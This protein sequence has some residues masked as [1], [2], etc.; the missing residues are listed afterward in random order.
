MENYIVPQRCEF[1]NGEIIDDYHIEK[2]LGEG[3]F[4]KV[5][6]V[7]KGNSDNIYALK[8]LKLWQVVHD[9][10]RVSLHKRFK[11][12]FDT[13]QINSEYLVKSMAYGI[14]NGNPYIV[15]KYC[16]NGDLRKYLG[17]NLPEETVDRIAQDILYGLRDLHA[18]GKVH[19]DIKPE[20]V[21]FDEK[22]RAML[23]DFGI[24]GDK[25]IRLTKRDIFGKNAGIFGTYAYMPP[26][27]LD[28]LRDAT[29]LPTTDFFSF[30]VMMY[31]VFTNELP[32]GELSSDSDLTNYIKNIKQGNWDRS[33]LTNRRISNKWVH[34][35]E[36]CVSPSLKKRFQNTNEIVSCIGRVKPVEEKPVSFNF[37]QD[38]LL[39]RIMQG[40][41]Y[42]KCYRLSDLVSK[43][44]SSIL[45][46]GRIDTG[47]RNDIAIRETESCYIS[48]L[49]ATIEKNDDIQKWVI[50]DGQ[51]KAPDMSMQG[52]WR[53]STNGTYVNSNETSHGGFVIVPGDIIAIGDVKL[54]VELY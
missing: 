45:T 39:L 20:N 43:S 6:K 54:R 38:N 47:V 53:R 29:V 10:D 13:G 30:G 36:K 26:E 24:S 5:Y 34:I 3:S 35:I 42:G 46:I 33:K 1:H 9:E 27:Q 21:L 52:T 50:R 51:W 22:N 28:R 40:E 41:E 12:E 48:R 17:S 44:K 49:H 4:G 37:R 15:M 19:R 7:S 11:M 2:T 14:I 16:P 18:N 32:F 23:T 31:E 8:L 25:N